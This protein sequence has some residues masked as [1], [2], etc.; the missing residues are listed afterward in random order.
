MEYNS[1]V[2]FIF[3]IS[4]AS[5]KLLKFYRFSHPCRSNCKII[6][7]FRDWWKKFLRLSNIQRSITWL[8]TCYWHPPKIIYMWTELS[9]S[10]ILLRVLSTFNL[11]SF[12]AVLRTKENHLLFRAFFINSWRH[13]NRKILLCSIFGLA[14]VT[15]WRCLWTLSYQ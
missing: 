15:S 13:R 7:I 5:S 8:V 1:T 6:F 11:T 9:C 2:D 4:T 14:S 3:V 12:S 10:L